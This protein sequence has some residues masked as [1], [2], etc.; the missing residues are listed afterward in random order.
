MVVRYD[1]TLGSFLIESD[2]CETCGDPL[3]DT[4]CDAPGCNGRFC[5]R[6]GTGCDLQS[7][8]ASGECATFAA[9]E[10]PEQKQ[11]RHNRERAAF[12]L[13]SL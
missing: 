2:N 3:S 1:D 9:V 5:D 13:P 7:D 10:T 4:G 11:A 8:P 12:G 6:C